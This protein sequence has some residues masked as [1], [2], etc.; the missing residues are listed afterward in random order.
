[1]AN[2]FGDDH[3]VALQKAIRVRSNILAEQPLL[4]SGG[5]ILNILDP[6]AYGWDKVRADAERDG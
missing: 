5:R 3:I 1:M 2:Y 4:A 6:D